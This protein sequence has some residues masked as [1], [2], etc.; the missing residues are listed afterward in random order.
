MIVTGRMIDLSRSERGG[1]TKRQIRIGQE[2]TKKREWLGSLI[3]KDISE[4]VWKKFFDARKKPKKDKQKII[5]GFSV[6]K[7]S[8]YWKPG[9]KDAPPI[10]RKSQS[11][12]KSKTLTLDDENFYRSQAWLELRYRVIRNQGRECNCCG[13]D[14]T[15]KGSRLHVDHI[16]PRSK[17]PHLALCYENLQV[18]CDACNLGKSN[19]FE[20]D[21]RKDPGDDWADGVNAALDNE[22]RSIIG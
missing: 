2:I 4:E 22:F 12:K 16:R 13:A 10:K 17:H 14:L 1:F 11:K 6:K 20:D 15:I 21:W 7:D 8:W 19:K 9:Q 18:L 3:G 5:N